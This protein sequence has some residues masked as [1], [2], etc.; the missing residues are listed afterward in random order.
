MFS[1]LLKDLISDFYLN[2]P[3]QSVRLIKCPRGAPLGTRYHG[4]HPHYLKFTEAHDIPSYSA[5]LGAKYS[6]G[7]PSLFE[8]FTDSCGPASSVECTSARCVDDRE[9]DHWVLRISFVEIW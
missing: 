6:T 7:A 3:L 8:T 4:V 9:V 2:H 1:L 5:T